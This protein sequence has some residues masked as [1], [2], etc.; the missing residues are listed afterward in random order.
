MAIF[1]SRQRRY[2]FGNACVRLRSDFHN[3]IKTGD[4]SFRR[5]S[6]KSASPVFIKFENHLARPKTAHFQTDTAAA[7]CEKWPYRSG[8]LFN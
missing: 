7:G 1:H 2:Q 5:C 8:C 3:L 6:E 4:A